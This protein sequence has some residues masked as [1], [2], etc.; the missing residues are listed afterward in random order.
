MHVFDQ[1]TPYICLVDN[2]R[3]REKPSLSAKVLAY[4]HTGQVVYTM[5]SMRVNERIVWGRYTGN[6]G[7]KRFIALATADQY[8]RYM[9][10][11]TINEQKTDQMVKTA[12]FIADDDSHGYSQISRWPS[13]GSDFDCS[14]LIYYCARKAGYHV[15]LM[16]YTGTMLADFT[17]AGFTPI[18]YGFDFP[19]YGDILL[20]E[21][22]HTEM[23]IGQ[24]KLVGAHSSETGGITGKPG[25]QTGREISICNFYNY[26]WDYILRPPK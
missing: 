20:N 26:P 15:P 9:L 1:K 4:Y 23:Y 22:D 3:V 8:K 12:I 14:S 16:G 24:N 2:L 21:T 7:K 11:A 19:Q 6:S 25:D 18:H 17:N 5:D 10:P 13:Q